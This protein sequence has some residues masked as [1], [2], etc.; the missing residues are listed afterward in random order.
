MIYVILY[1]LTWLPFL[2]LF[3]VKVLGR[4]NLPKK[5]GAI[6]VCNHYSMFDGIILNGKLVRKI[7]YLMKAELFKNKF[8][9]WFYKKILCC[10]PVNRGAADVSAIKSGLK[11]I[12]DGHLL[13]IFPEGTR[14]KDGD[15]AQTGA[16]HGG[17]IMFASRSGAPIVPTLIYK[18]PKLF[19]PNIVIVG[20]PYY[21]T[22]ENPNKL[23]EEE[24]QAAIIELENKM[25]ELRNQ[26]DLKYKKK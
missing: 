10:I 13:G 5:Q 22:G 25:A 1:I 18:R 11:T 6:L 4:K 7:R 12:K 2:I 15:E 19:R 9:A 8:M 24:M 3:P 20:E 23:T 14:N 21:V 17:A 26:L 16:L